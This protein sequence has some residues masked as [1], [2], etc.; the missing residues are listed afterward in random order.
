MQNVFSCPRVFIS[1]VSFEHILIALPLTFGRVHWPYTEVKKFFTTQ[2]VHSI[3]SRLTMNNSTDNDN[4]LTD[5]YSNNDPNK[6]TLETVMV[7]NCVLNAPLML[8]SI[9]GNALVLAT[10]IK[11]PS[12][13]STSMHMLC[14][15]AVSDLLVGVI[16]QPLY[17]ASELSKESSLATATIT[18]GFYFCLVSLATV[19]AIS[20][21]RYVALHYHMRYPTLVTHSRVRYTL[22]IIWM[23]SFLV[24]SVYF[25]NIKRLLRLLSG[26]ISGILLLISTFSYFRIYLI[27]RRH[28]SQI[29]AQQQAVQ[30]ISAENGARMMRL[31]QSALNTFVFYIVLITCYFPMY[32]ILTLYG[33]SYRKLQVERNFVITLVF[34]NSS[35]NPFLYC[36]RI[37]ELRVA[38]VKTARQMFCKQTDENQ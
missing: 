36:W 31:K 35:I 14:S 25:L 38:V 10:I 21:D 27:V 19:T 2:R 5:R 22:V 6:T 7:I 23:I 20:V 13:R 16:S 8:I 33:I 11:T 9:L 34:M 3:L 24:N 18:I 12:I 30:T 1:T 32:I 37:R 29:H 26:V 4:G 17:I 28:H 15:L